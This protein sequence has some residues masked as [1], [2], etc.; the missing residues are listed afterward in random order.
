MD[1]VH[2]A[3]SLFPILLSLH[4][5]IPCDPDLTREATGANIASYSPPLLPVLTVSHT[6][7]VSG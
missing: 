4:M 6:N 3:N 7:A 2:T 5:P 1:I